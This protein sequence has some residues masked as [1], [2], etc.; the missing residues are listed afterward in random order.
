MFLNEMAKVKMMNAARRE[1]A[2]EFFDGAVR[3]SISQN[4][5]FVYED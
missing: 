1:L 3:F 5:I 2:K 4:F